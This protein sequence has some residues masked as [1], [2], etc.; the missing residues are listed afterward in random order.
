MLVVNNNA[1]PGT[2][3]EVAKTDAREVFETK[4]GYGHATRRGLMR[5]ERRPHRP[6]RARRDLPPRGHQQ[7]ARLQQRVRCGLRHPDHARADLGRGQHG[8]VPALGQLG[9][10]EAGRGAVQHEPPLATWAAPTGSSTA[11]S[12]I[13]S[14]QMKVG[15]NHAGRRDP[16]DHSHLGRPLCRDPG[17][18]PAPGRALISDRSRSGR[19]SSGCG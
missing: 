5:G 2:S 9:R 8:L 6:R 4:Q 12:R 11:S 1:Q 18:L 10:R 7:A 17:E 15:G 16:A 19:S 13:T 3:E 14:R